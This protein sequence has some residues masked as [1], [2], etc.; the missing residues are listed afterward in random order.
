M[1]PTDIV[2]M[3]AYYDRMLDANNLYTAFLRAKQGS[4]WKAS[5]QKFEAGVL[6]NINILIK[7]LK[8]KS[9]EQKP[10][11]EFTLRE[12]G[13]IR[14]I[15]SIHISD[16]IV[17]R[18]LC[19]NILVPTI[20]PKLIYDNGA[21]V[22]NKGISFSRNRLT[23][24][25][26]RY[27]RKHGT[28]GYILLIDFSKFFDNINHE[29]ILKLSEKTFKD[30][31]LLYLLSSLIDTFKVDVSHLSTKEQ[32]YLYNNVLDTVKFAESSPK[33]KRGTSYLRKSLGIGS[34][35]S[36]I[37]GVYYPTALD[38]LCKI[39]YKCKYYGRYMDDI[40]IIHSDKQYLQNLLDDV[41]KISDVLGLHVNRRKTKITP[42]KRGFTFLQ[43]KYSLTPSGKIVKRVKPDR[44]IR[45]R[46]RLKKYRL[47]LE[48]NKITQD[49]IRNAYYSWR[50]NLEKFSCNKSLTNLDTLYSILFKEV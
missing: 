9:Y 39:H 19:D 11:F 17:Q 35:I 50:G 15:R 37:F 26:T 2:L 22:K 46:R 23:T 28:D 5:V 32:D 24:H 12:R 29:S 33:I 4:S 47:L 45:E 31:S 30:D 43:V 42:L 41:L 49:V 3:P 1:L 7:T 18:C 16:R 48:N 34:Q 36:Q 21:S 6:R 14:H 13:K 20:S 40:Y 10:F 27:I 38:R 44:F 8:N 25:L